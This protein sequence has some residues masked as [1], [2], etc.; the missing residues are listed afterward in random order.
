MNTFRQ[1]LAFLS[2]SSLLDL[3]GRAVQAL[4]AFFRVPPRWCKTISRYDS[5]TLAPAPSLR[6]AFAAPEL[7]NWELPLSL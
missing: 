4:S 6:F 1:R 3:R 2:S 5:K 7:E